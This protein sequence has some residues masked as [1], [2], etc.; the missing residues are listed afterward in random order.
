M[1]GIKVLQPSDFPTVAAFPALANAARS[2]PIS[3]AYRMQHNGAPFNV[4]LLE[5]DISFASV[6][7]QL[8]PSIIQQLTTT[9]WDFCY[10]GHENSG[11]I[12]RADSR[13]EKLS[14]WRLPATFSARISCSSIAVSCPRL[15]AHLERVANGVRRRS[16]LRPNA[17][18]MAPTTF[19]VGSMRDVRTLVA[20]PK[21]GWQRP[22]RSDSQ[23][24]FI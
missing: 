14:W 3:V 18:S 7:P 1:G 8:T 5:D 19:S 4:M 23:S 21:L 2:S 13:T 11:D 22:S 24:A 15:V 9:A 12:A 17:E 16:D 6:L 10:L 20:V